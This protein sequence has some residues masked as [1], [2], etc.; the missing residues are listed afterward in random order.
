[1]VNDTC[2]CVLTRWQQK[3]GL[4]TAIKTCSADATAKYGLSSAA[5]ANSKGTGR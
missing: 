2:N 3:L 1:M 4:D 5:P